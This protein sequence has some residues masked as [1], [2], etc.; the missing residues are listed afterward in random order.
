V[1]FLIAAGV[2]RGRA[3]LGSAH[4]EGNGISFVQSH[5]CCTGKIEKTLSR[6]G[7]SS[8][9]LINSF[10]GLNSLYS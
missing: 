10:I 5:P 9:R 2:P 3:L 6:R 4:R 7:K 8:K 1:H